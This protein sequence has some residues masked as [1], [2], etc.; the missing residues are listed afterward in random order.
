[1]KANRGNQGKHGYC[2]VNRYSCGKKG[3][4]GNKA[5][6]DNSGKNGNGGKHANQCNGDTYGKPAVPDLN[7]ADRW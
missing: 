6:Y 4:H 2:Q 7:H 5:K 3:N 1:M